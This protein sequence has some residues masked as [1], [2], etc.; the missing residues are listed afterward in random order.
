M[1]SSALRLVALL[2]TPAPSAALLFAATAPVRAAKAPVRA[3][4][5]ASLPVEARAPVPAGFAGRR[6]LLAGVLV[7]LSAPSSALAEQVLTMD[8]DLSAPSAAQPLEEAKPLAIS[9][10]DVAEAG[11]R[12]GGRFGALSPLQSL[13]AATSA[14]AI[15]THFT[16]HLAC[17][18]ASPAGLLTRR[19]SRFV[20]PCL[21]RCG[22]H[23]ANASD[24]VQKL[25]NVSSEEWLRE[26]ADY[27]DDI[28]AVV[29]NL[30]HLLKCCQ[31]VSPRLDA[32][33]DCFA[34]TPEVYA[35]CRARL[36]PQ[37]VT[38]Q[39]CISFVPWPRP[40]DKCRLGSAIARVQCGAS[41]MDDG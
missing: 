31:Q 12:A 18:P 24:A 40:H 41:A 7:A 35:R 21:A 38:R 5:C 27:R 4:S 29:L 37:T 13:M 10:M 19:L 26:E 15:S 3:V 30:P 33:L 8:D 36:L 39:A 6:A 22:D 11:A 20:S 9:V 1:H 2:L 17:Q 28:T 32:P 16:V 25:V 14:L 23:Q 34:C